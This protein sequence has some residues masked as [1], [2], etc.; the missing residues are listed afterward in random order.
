MFLIVAY[1]PPIIVPA[2]ST[3]PARSKIVA[4]ADKSDW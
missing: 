2:F 3:L 1:P 4:V